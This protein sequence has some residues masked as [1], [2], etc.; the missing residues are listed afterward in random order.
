MPVNIR[1]KEKLESTKHTYNWLHLYIRLFRLFPPSVVILCRQYGD[2]ATKPITS[3]VSIL[4][5]W[6]NKHS[7][8][9]LKS[10]MFK[11]TLQNI[12]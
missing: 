7:I 1:R 10:N 8:N 4:I 6:L 5:R 9:G 3:V 11:I 2:L 12:P